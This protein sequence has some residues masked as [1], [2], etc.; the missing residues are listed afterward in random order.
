MLS[1][2]K[3]KIELDE[4]VKNFINSILISQAIDIADYYSQIYS[5][6]V[7]DILEDKEKIKVKLNTDLQSEAIN[8]AL[9]KKQFLSVLISFIGIIQMWN[10]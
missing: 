6:E 8:R 4:N 1:A 7:V 2:F 3:N 10:G 9:C 5:V